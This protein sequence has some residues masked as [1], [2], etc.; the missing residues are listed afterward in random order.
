MAIVIKLRRRPARSAE[1]LRRALID[2]PVKERWERPFED[3]TVQDADLDFALAGTAERDG[4]SS[5]TASK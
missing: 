5:S 1:L 2:A 4:D 3:V